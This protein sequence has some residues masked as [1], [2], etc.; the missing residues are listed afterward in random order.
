MDRFWREKT[1]SGVQSLGGSQSE[2]VYETEITD[3]SDGP[4]HVLHEK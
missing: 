3:G 1:C 2:K 4:A